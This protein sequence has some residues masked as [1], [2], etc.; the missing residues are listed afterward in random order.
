MASV[1]TTLA[2]C[3][4]QGGKGRGWV[5]RAGSAARGCGGGLQGGRWDG[6]RATAGVHWA[7]QWLG[8]AGRATSLER[9]GHRRHW[10]HTAMSHAGRAAP[11]LARARKIFKIFLNLAGLFD[12]K[13]NY[14][15][16]I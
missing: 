13:L 9:L 15:L 7:R 1:G 2:C 10:E 11:I 3:G 8:A 6:D 16:N 4:A 14:L 5:E 12:N